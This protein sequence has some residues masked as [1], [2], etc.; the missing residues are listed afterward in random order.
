MSCD[1]QQFVHAAA[2]EG[3]PCWRVF[4]PL[5]HT[6]RAFI[7]HNAFGKSGF[8]FASAEYTDPKSVDYTNVSVPNAKWHESHTFVCFAYPTYSEDDIEQIARGI[9][10]VIRAYSQAR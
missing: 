6:E 4:W 7:E 3:V 5:C 10:K 2:A 1:I 8:P 9:V